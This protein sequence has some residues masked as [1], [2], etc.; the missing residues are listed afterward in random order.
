MIRMTRMHLINWHNFIDDII[1]F[2]NVT[3]LIGLNAVGKTTIMDAVRYCLTT[4]KDFNAA[5]NRKSGRTLQGS[6]HQKQ[7]AEDSYLRP[8]HTVT[9][10][11]IEFLD[12]A[13]QKTFVITVRVESESPKQE[14]RHVSQ[15][16]YISK[17]GFS[18]IDLPFFTNTKAGRRPASREEFK[19]DNKGMDKAPSQGEAR[20]RISRVLGIGDADSQIGKKFNEV[21][22]MGTSLEDIN[23]IRKFIYTYI[24][25][26]PE[27]NVEILHKDMRELERLQ[28]ILEEAQEREKVLA[29]INEKMLVAKEYDSKVKVNEALVSYAK[30]QDAI[31]Q[32]DEEKLKILQARSTIEICENKLQE[33]LEK[34]KEAEQQLYIARK[35]FD[36]NQENRALSFLEEENESKNKEYN[37]LVKNA[38]R[39]DDILGQM[40]KLTKQLE[41]LSIQCDYDMSIICDEEA[42]LEHR[43]VAIQSAK[44]ALYGVSEEIKE[45]DAEI[46]NRLRVLSGEANELIMKI[47]KLEAGTMCYPKEAELVR[48]SINEKL[49]ELGKKPDAKLFCELLYMNDSQW[50]D[51]VESYLNMQRFNIIVAPDNYLTAKAVFV[52]LQDSV[53]GIGLVDTERLMKR[54][55]S[56]ESN[57]KMLSFTVESKNP[58]A[59]AYAD[60]LMGGVVCCETKEELELHNKSVTKDRLRYQSYCLQRMKKQDRFIGIDA[61]QQQLENARTLLKDKRQEQQETEIRKKLYSD[62]DNM[63]RLFISGNAFVDLET[64]CESKKE[65][66]QLYESISEIKNQ[67]EEFKK[68]PILMSMYNRVEECEKKHSELIKL[69]TDAKGDKKNA[70]DL[71]RNAE[72]VIASLQQNMNE[73]QEEY[74]VIIESHALYIETVVTKYNEERKNKRASAIVYNFANRISQDMKA[75]EKYLNLELVPLQRK[76]MGTYTC[77]YPEGLVGAERYRQAYASLVNISLE[78]HKDALNRAQIRC[79]ERFRKEILFRMKDDILRARQQFRQ[80]NKVMEHLSYGEESY[81]FAIDGNKDKELSIFYNIIMDKDNQQIDEENEIVAFFATNQ[82]KVFESQIEEFMQRIMVDVENHAQETLTGQKNGAKNI[83]AYV[84]YRTYLDYDIIVKNAVTGLEVPLSKVSGDGSGGENQAPFYVSICASLL[85]IYQQS[86]NCIRLVLLDEAFNNM[87]SDRI[88]PMMKM[89]RDLNLQLVLI[90]TPEKCTSIFP[91]CDITYSIVK[92]GSRNAIAGFEGV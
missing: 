73:A 15:D 34:E 75:L 48:D 42:L 57:E 39:F 66:D 90:A 33:L 22:H 35:D 41:I 24:L 16:W 74:N 32:K 28:E 63:Y 92:H 10:I 18:I 45:N 3:Y 46:R 83:S 70:E 40:K 54:S 12:E 81:R 82:S 49:V 13:I 43:I 76:Y 91:Y 62:L 14:L 38:A 29:E 7:R 77:D 59:R 87:T 69:I 9:Y 50:Q 31:E 11:G 26:E 36:D 72:L 6:V 86:D 30:L 51:A 79:K 27:I 37:K 67:I 53:R 84:D 55:N 21:F 44:Q 19:L 78:Q 65:A 71:I 89:F 61:L 20:R 23:D 25:P 5:G 1:D 2:K 52:S 60:Y 80:L 85:Q 47:N 4:N 88:E 17:P 64:F 58:Y 8:N 68:N 56:N